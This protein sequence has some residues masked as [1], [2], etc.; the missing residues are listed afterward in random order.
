MIKVWKATQQTGTRSHSELFAKRLDTQYYKS[1]TWE[2]VEVDACFVL[3]NKDYPEEGGGPVSLHRTLESAE[4][5]G[6]KLTF[7][8]TVDVWEIE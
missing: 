4:K 3:I 7:G 1:W 5:A 6:K 8:G 2:Q